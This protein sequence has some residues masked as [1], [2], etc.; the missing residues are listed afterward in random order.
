MEGPLVQ[1]PPNGIQNSNP[2]PP[3]ID[4]QVIVD[5]LVKVL[6]VTLGASEEDLR[7]AGSLLS[8]SKLQ[9]T[10]QRCTRF[11][12]ETQVALYAQ[13]DILDTSRIGGLESSQ[14]KL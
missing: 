9:D 3:S 14:G 10:L 7:V 6:N 1:G 13:K 11:A 12:L 2:A 5:H 4:P 8:P